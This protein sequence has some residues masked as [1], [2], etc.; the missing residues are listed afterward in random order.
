MQESK[1]RSSAGEFNRIDLHDGDNIIR[2]TSTDYKE[3]YVFFLQDT[4]GNNAKVQMTEDKG[5]NRETYADVFN[6]STDQPKLRFAF[7]ALVGEVEKIRDSK[8]HKVTAT[9]VLDN[10]V[11]VLECGPQIAKQIFDLA[12]DEEEPDITD[13]NMRITKEGTGLK[14]KYTVKLQK[15]PTPLPDDIIDDVDLEIIYA[16]TSLERVAE[17]LGMEY[18]GAEPEAE[19]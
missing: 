13:V 10:T 17:I 12:L 19:A 6:A 11:Q 16:P 14:T 8:T 18:D 7:K 1:Q 9:V 2:I 3:G 5:Y 4:E 15:Q